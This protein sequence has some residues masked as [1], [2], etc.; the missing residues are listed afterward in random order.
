MVFSQ[1]ESQGTAFSPHHP[2][3]QLPVPASPL[4]TQRLRTCVGAP[5][6]PQLPSCTSHPSSEMVLSGLFIGASGAPEGQ[7]GGVNNLFSP[8]PSLQSPL[9][10]PLHLY[11]HK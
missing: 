4:V 2:Q 1:W 9:P 8:F 6:Q 10:S 7:D 3:S 5:L 11:S